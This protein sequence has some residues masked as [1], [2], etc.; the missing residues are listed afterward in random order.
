[1]KRAVVWAGVSSQQQVEDKDSLHRQIAEGESLCLRQGWTIVERLEVPGATRN[2]VD[3]QDAIEGLDEDLRRL[4]LLVPN[5]YR[6]LSLLI[7]KRQLD[8]LVVRSRDRLGRTDSLIAGIEER[9]RRADAML[10]SMAMPP[11]GQRAGDFYISAIER[12]SAQHEIERLRERRTKGMDDRLRRGLTLTGQL[13]FPYLEE[14]TVKG[15]KPVRRA[16]PDPARVESYLWA[17]DVTLNREMTAK[18]IGARLRELYPEFGWSPPKLRDTLKNPMPVGLLIRRRPARDGEPNNMIVYQELDTPYW[19]EIERLLL[20]RMLHDRAMS[21]K[22]LETPRIWLVTAGQ[23]EA[24]IEPATWLELQR[25]LDTRAV[26]RRPPSRNRIWS[27]LLWCSRCGSHMYATTSTKRPGYSYGAY[28][29]SEKFL[30]RTCD[31]PQVAETEVTRQMLEYLEA[32]RSS[33]PVAAIADAPTSHDPQR[34]LERQAIAL[35]GRVERVGLLYETG[36]IGI[37]AYD[38]RMAEL[39]IKRGKIRQEMQAL[40][41]KRVRE[42]RISRNMEEIVVSPL[43]AILDGDHVVANRWLRGIIS[44]IWVDNRMVVGVEL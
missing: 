29:C 28:V 21:E 39:A 43:Q 3:L 37:D 15:G 10:Y 38:S 26:G 18:E 11:T 31:N 27:G 33:V 44:K 25:F 9:L 35:A 34:E 22:K 32:L 42:T 36:R 5:A 13:P 24:V 6:E 20:H 41:E 23:H 19:D 14:R 40:A 2:Y 4:G 17:V 8:V 7:V 16:V 12:A 30:N 1:V